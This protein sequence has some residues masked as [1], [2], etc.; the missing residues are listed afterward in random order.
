M[1]MMLSVSVDIGGIQIFTSLLV[2]DTVT[3]LKR[4][5][6]QLEIY[7]TKLFSNY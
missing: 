3:D 1:R 4:E 6:R 2:T 5:T 7:F